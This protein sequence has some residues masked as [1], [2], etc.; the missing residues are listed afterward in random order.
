[1]NQAEDRLHRMGQQKVVRVY[2]LECQGSFDQSVGRIN[3]NKAEGIR[4]ALTSESV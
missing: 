4:R 2:Y 1:M 3:V